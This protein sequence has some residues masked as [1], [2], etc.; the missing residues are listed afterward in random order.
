MFRWTGDKK[1]LREGLSKAG[2]GYDSAEWIE[3]IS[4]GEQGYVVQ[5]ATSI[6]V[7]TAKALHER[8]VVFVDVFWQ[9]VSEHIPASHLMEEGAG[10]LTEAELL[11]VVAKN[12]EVVFCGGDARSV[13]NASAKAVTWGFEKVYHFQ[14]GTQAWK[15]AGYPVEGWKAE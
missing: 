9:W 13:A 5:R 4:S 12:E 7:T 11:Q 15:N 2:V 10:E 3:L 14:G 6:D 8:G 1:S